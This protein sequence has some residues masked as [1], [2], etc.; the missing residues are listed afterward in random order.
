MK[1]RN[2]IIFICLIGLLCVFSFNLGK[3]FNTPILTKADTELYLEGSSEK[4]TFRDKSGHRVNVLTDKDGV[5]Y[6]PINEDNLFLDYSVDKTE[7]KIV[8]NRTDYDLFVD[9]NTKTFDGAI[10]T[11]EDIYS[12][13]FT[14]F[15]NW[16]TWCPD[17]KALLGNLSENIDKLKEENIQI[18]G[19]PI[20]EGSFED[21]KEKVNS[22]L[23]EY[24]LD[25]VNLVCTDRMKEQL[26]SNIANIP[27]V[28]LVDNRGKIL[29]NNDK[30]NLL[31]TDFLNDLENIDVCNEC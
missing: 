30:T 28:I 29:Y 13:D 12:N 9:I 4:Y 3:S 16:T 14:L 26:Q 20:Y 27:S 15:L 11:N 24:N 17:C 22:I 10:F 19:L 6:L 23:N 5:L 2:I 25:F 18:I 21:E 8:L 31:I 1:I 7:D